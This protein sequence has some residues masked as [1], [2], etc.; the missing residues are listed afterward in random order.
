MQC[1]N[2]VIT[3]SEMEESNIFPKYLKQAKELF[4]SSLLIA[5]N[6][7]PQETFQEI[8]LNAGWCRCTVGPG[9]G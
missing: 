1:N 8:C 9:R 5:E 4:A 7:C 2:R 6:I 3:G